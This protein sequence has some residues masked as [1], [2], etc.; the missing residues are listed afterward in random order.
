[1]RYD[2]SLEMALR[3]G[4]EQAGLKLPELASNGRM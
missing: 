4:V 3:A 2:R 1:V